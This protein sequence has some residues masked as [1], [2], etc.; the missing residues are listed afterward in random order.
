VRSG[1]LTPLTGLLPEFTLNPDDI[2][3][4]LRAEMPAAS[5]AERVRRAQADSDARVD[6]AI[7]ERRSFLVE[8]VLSSDKFRGRVERALADGFRFGFVFVTLRVAALHVA[9]V[10]DRVDDGGHDVPTERVLARR[11]RSHSAFGW[12]AGRARRGLLIDNSGGP[13]PL[14]AGPILVA[15]KRDG[16]AA[17]RVLR[18]DLQ[19]GLVASLG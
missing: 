4:A 6:R 9:R 18:R 19:P 16:D 14:G 7:Q 12:F 1:A 10:A 3:L 2:A 15:E 5:E 8:T 17:W 11:E 13:Q